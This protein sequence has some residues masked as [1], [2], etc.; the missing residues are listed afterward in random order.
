MGK[1]IAK[2][3]SDL[4][5]NKVFEKN[6]ELDNIIKDNKIFF[7]L[8]IQI[9]EVI[10]FKENPDYKLDNGSMFYV[11]YS[12]SNEEIKNTI[13]SYFDTINSSSEILSLSQS[14]L[15]NI[16]FLFYG[17]KI[18]G[19]VKLNLQNITPKYFVKSKSFLKMNTHITYQHEENILEFKNIFDLH[20][21]EKNQKIY[22]RDFSHLRKLHKDFIDLYKEATEKEKNDFI[23]EINKKSLFEIDKSKLNLQSTNLK[24]LK[25]IL[26]NDILTSVFK[27]ENKVT[28]YVKRYQTS[29]SLSLKDGKYIINDNKDFTALL[30]IIN[31]NFYQGEITGKKLESNSNKVL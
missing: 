3:K 26:D 18:D 2:L 30:K 11:D 23:N 24:K 31:E 22:F 7:G 12:N 16:D 9:E 1:F 17:K 20:I 25:Y 21:D 15:K 29:L 14:N 27:K 28:K 19:K 6:V 10:E 4:G 8:D 5:F 13:N